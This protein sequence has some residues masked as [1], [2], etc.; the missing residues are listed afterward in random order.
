MDP[1]EQCPDVMPNQNSKR[2]YP[3]GIEVPS[4]Y[5]PSCFFTAEGNGNNG[6]P[7]TLAEISSDGIDDN[8]IISLD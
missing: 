8:L 6:S 1:E 5:D 3:D 7:T 2:F 4:P